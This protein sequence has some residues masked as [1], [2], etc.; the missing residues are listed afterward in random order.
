[1]VGRETDDQHGEPSRSG[2][3]IMRR[4]VKPKRRLEASAER[5]GIPFVST[6]AVTN[7]IFQPLAQ[8]LMDRH[9]VV[10]IHVAH[11]PV[12]D[13][14]EAISVLRTVIDGG[15]CEIGAHLYPCVSAPQQEVIK[16]LNPFPGNLPSAF[17]REKLAK[18][19]ARD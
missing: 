19:T 14:S 2:R 9:V 10:P 5:V 16:T 4:R 17:E 11:Y 12:G 8:Q 1:M 7:I 18:L 15:R 6:L 3:A 13:S